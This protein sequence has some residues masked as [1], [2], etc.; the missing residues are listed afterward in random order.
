M[1]SP[2]ACVGC[3]G[4][5][6]SLFLYSSFRIHR[7]EVLSR[8][9]RACRVVEQLVDRHAARDELL[10]VAEVDDDVQ[11]RPAGLD[12]ETVGIERAAVG[13]SGGPFAVVQLAEDVLDHV[14]PRARQL[15]PDHHHVI[16]RDAVVAL[17]PFLRNRVGVGNEMLE[18]RIGSL[19][20]TIPAATSP[21]SS[22]CVKSL[23]AAARLTM[24]GSWYS[25]T[26][27][28]SKVIHSTL[29]MS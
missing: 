16:D 20:P 2:Q 6:P 27:G 28:S 9:Q 22:I 18:L 5:L 25:A 8:S 11:Y 12:A 13:Q 21:S 26:W 3:S 1:E 14:R 7:R 24:A 15:L 19:S 17:G 10:L 29:S 4:P 23:P